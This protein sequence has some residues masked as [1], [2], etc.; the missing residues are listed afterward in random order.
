[1]DSE[2]LMGRYEGRKLA[3]NA[4]LRRGQWFIAAAFLSLLTNLQDGMPWLP[5]VLFGACVLGFF[6]TGFVALN[7]CRCPN[8]DQIPIKISLW[9]WESEIPPNPAICPHCKVRLRRGQARFP[10]NA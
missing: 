7:K 2:D 10:T 1:M 4:T 3:A 8:C 9:G 5:V 6:V